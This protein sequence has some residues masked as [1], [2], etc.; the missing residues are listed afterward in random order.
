AA[1]TFGGR[2]RRE[3]SSIS[4]VCS[5]PCSLS[6]SAS[7]TFS[8]SARNGWETE[9]EILFSRRGGDRGH[10]LACRRHPPATILTISRRSPAWSCR[11]ENSDGAT[12]S[13]LCSTTTLRGKSSCATRNS[14]MEQG[15]LVAT[16]LP[17]A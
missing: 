4:A 15:S 13:P 2:S 16:G 7:G 11:V 9:V 6:Q 3:E 10:K 5:L 14:S 12:A 1:T 17:L 8:A